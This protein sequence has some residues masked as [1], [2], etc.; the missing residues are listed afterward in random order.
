MNKATADVR[1]LA[2]VHGPAAIKELVRLSTQ[3]EG[4]GARIAAIKELLD[5]GFGKSPQPLTGEGGS[6]PAEIVIR[7]EI[8]K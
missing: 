7:R 6:G 8:V 2:S 1:A 4:E 5:R 3:A